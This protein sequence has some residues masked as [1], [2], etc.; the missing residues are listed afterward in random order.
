MCVAVTVSD[1]P[2]GMEQSAAVMGYDSGGHSIIIAATASL[3]LVTVRTS[4]GCH[5]DNDCKGFLPAVAIKSGIIDAPP[6][7]PCDAI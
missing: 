3:P 1:Q 2:G 4:P 6:C 7:L 5:T